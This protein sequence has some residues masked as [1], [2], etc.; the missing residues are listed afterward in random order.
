[1]VVWTE[2]NEEWEEE[3]T[4][5]T[6]GMFWEVIRTTDLLARR[7]VNT[8]YEVTVS[9]VDAVGLLRVVAAPRMAHAWRWGGGGG[10]HYRR[11]V[12]TKWELCDGQ[13][14]EQIHATLHHIPAPPPLL[15]RKASTVR[16][17]FFFFYILCRRQS[18]FCTCCSSPAH[19][20]CFCEWK[21]AQFDTSALK[22]SPSSYKHQPT[23]ASFLWNIL[24]YTRPMLCIITITMIIRTTAIILRGID[25]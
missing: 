6:T 9:S 23:L 21:D 12:E 17:L 5:K 2:D 14:K 25:R 19:S 15:N 8:M 11:T 3:E 22:I 24:C 13:K 10:G 1:M 7:L 18:R 16:F 20:C 4:T